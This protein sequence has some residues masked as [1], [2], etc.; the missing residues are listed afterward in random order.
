MATFDARRRSRAGRTPFGLTLLLA[1]LAT[2]AHAASPSV[3]RGRYLVETILAC[4]NC[5]TPKDASGQPIA[6]RNLSGGLAFDIPPFAGVASNITPDRET[7][8]GAWSDEEIKRAITHGERPRHGRLAGVA[9]APVMASGFFKALTPGDLDAVVAY[10]R[11][12]PAV[13]N[14]VPP[15]TY[16]M[17]VPHERYPEAE[18]GFG[19]ADLRDPVR[20]GAYLVTIAHCMECHTPAEKGRTLYESALG[21][22]GKRFLPGMVTG[23]PASWPGA[24]ARNITSHPESGLG[25]WSDA[26]IKRAITDGVSRDGRKL[27]PPMGYSWYAGLR[28]DDL[29]AIVAYLRTVPPQP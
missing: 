1:V 2:G 24:T 16:R 20:R 7:G 19:D 3:E 17:Q 10:L 25:R 28:D 5:H 8:I 23:L 27:L 29:D 11:A 18:R 21:A 22:G 4:G 13:R 14:A 6:A 12:V 15:P 26:Q 9:L